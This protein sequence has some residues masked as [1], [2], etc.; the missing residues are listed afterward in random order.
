[1]GG[2]L[3]RT[4]VV[5][6]IPETLVLEAAD[7]RLGLSDASSRRLLFARVAEHLAGF[8]GADLE[9]LLSWVDAQG[10]A[11]PPHIRLTAGRLAG[12]GPHTPTPGEP[13]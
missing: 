4:E 3:L 6:M 11:V 5:G 2:R 8:R 12:S 1:R 10:E 7:D 13:G 9:T